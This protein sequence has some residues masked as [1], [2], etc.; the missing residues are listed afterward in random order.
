MAYAWRTGRSDADVI[1]PHATGPVPCAP[2]WLFIGSVVLTATQ[3]RLSGA[4]SYGDR[5]G[6]PR[7]GRCWLI[8]PLL[9]PAERQL[10]GAQRCEVAGAGEG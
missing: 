4:E 10:G 6:P 9:C 8:R 2:T 5:E 3:A 7:A 1:L